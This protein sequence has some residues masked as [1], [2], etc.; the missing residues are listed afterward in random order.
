MQHAEK[1]FSMNAVECKQVFLLRNNERENCMLTTLDL[2]FLKVKYL[3]YHKYDAVLLS[4][5]YC[6]Q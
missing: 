1:R 3:I 5:T 6:Y 2:N 4:F